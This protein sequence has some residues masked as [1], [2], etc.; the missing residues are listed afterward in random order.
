MS[1]LT[2]Q[3][4]DFLDDID[5][6]YPPESDDDLFLCGQ[7]WWDTREG[8]ENHANF[9]EQVWC[10]KPKIYTRQ[11]IEQAQHNYKQNWFVAGTW[12]ATL[13]QAQEY[14]NR[15]L[16]QT[17]EYRVVYSRAEIES[18]GGDEP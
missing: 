15:H 7:E 1:K 11:E 4:I 6:N 10:N 2:Q 5:W 17:G 18:L 16:H 14:A 9:C 3:E 12:H 8:A 13:K